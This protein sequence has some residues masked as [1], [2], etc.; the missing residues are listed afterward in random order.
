MTT[1]G[2]TGA[3]TT[4]RRT[5]DGRWAVGAVLVAGAVAV[6]LLV[7]V[8]GSRPDPEEAPPASTPATI[9]LAVVGDMGA[10]NS[11]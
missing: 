6:A 8:A 3:T 10:V 7:T 2:V 9:H 11:H 5:R 1:G 4:G